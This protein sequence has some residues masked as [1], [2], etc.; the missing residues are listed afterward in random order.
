M[1]DGAILV[2]SVALTSKV[3]HRADV[4]GDKTNE[5]RQCC[6]NGWMLKFANFLEAFGQG[7][8]AK[9]SRCSPS[10][11]RGPGPYNATWRLQCGQ[12]SLYLSL[13]VDLESIP[14]DQQIDGQKAQAG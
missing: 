1:N 6:V 7:M 13:P 3:R 14:I 5:G 10:P 8:L 12:H 11:G 4:L 2:V 9:Q